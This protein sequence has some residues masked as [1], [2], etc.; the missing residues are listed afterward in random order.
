MPPFSQA[1]PFNAPH[2]DQS[3]FPG[4]P[5]EVDDIAISN[6][7]SSLKNPSSISVTILMRSSNRPILALWLAW[8][9]RAQIQGWRGAPLD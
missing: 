6:V 8:T 1:T 2:R 9:Y 5:V 7:F 4:W 3:L